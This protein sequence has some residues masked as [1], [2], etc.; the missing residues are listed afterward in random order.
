MEWLW[1]WLG[2]S[3]IAFTHA[4][5]PLKLKTKDGKETD[6][7]R[8]CEASTPT[9]CLNPFLFNG[10]VQTI[11]TAVKDD[12]PSVFYKRKIFDAE[13]LV[14]EGAALQAP[15]ISKR[16]HR[17][18]EDDADEKVREVFGQPPKVKRRKGPST[19]PKFKKCPLPAYKSTTTFNSSFFLARHL[20]LQGTHA[21]DP[22]E[23]GDLAREVFQQKKPPPKDLS[24]SKRC[25]LPNCSSTALFRFAANLRKHLTSTIHGLI[26][27]LH[28]V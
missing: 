2:Y 12:G 27:T 16:F 3:R 26:M 28:G 19:D 8:L 7:L 4:T 24:K 22:E 15:L 9:C 13:D 18:S 10:H 23:A 25:P 1:E 14:Y 11:W 6:L 20:R 5:A 17:M 21:M